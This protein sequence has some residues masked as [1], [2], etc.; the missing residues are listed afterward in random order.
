VTQ[1]IYGKSVSNTK[2]LERGN[3]LNISAENVILALENE[4]FLLEVFFI[5]ESFPE[6]ALL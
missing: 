6:T 2:C 5:E 1:N 3:N 4:F